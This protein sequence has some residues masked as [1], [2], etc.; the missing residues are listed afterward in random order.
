MVQQDH[1]VYL[2]KEE[3][4]VLLVQ[5]VLMVQLVHLERMEEMELL[6]IPVFRERE[7]C[8]GFQVLKEVLESL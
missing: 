4:L 7:D 3:L 6:E 1:L 8:K 5:M 2:E